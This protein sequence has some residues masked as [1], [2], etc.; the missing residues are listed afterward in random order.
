M[1]DESVEQTNAKWR[2]RRRMAFVALWAAI[3]ETAL[4]IVLAVLDAAGRLSQFESFLIAT[5]GGFFALAGAYM[6]V[7]TW[8][9]VGRRGGN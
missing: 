1:D 2:Y 6:G 5:A 9:D 3:L 7:A 8:Y 4:V